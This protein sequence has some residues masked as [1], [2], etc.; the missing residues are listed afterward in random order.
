MTPTS[1]RNRVVHDD[2]PR[3]SRFVIAVALLASMAACSL[4]TDLGGLS[5][6]D[7]RD[8]GM[9]TSDGPEQDAAAAVDGANGSPT[10]GGDA[11]R[12]SDAMT[13]DA[14]ATSRYASAVIADA[15]TS[16]YRFGELA[17]PT[18]HDEMHLHDAVYRGAVTFGAAGALAGDPNASIR[19][20]G[21]QMAAVDFG[22]SFDCAGG[23]AFSIELWVDDHVIDSEYRRVFWTFGTDGG[24]WGFDIEQM[25]GLGVTFNGS[26]SSSVFVS[27]FPLAR[28]V[29]LAV[30]Y[31]TATLR[32]YLDGTLAGTGGSVNLPASSARLYLGMTDQG[33]NLFNGRIDELAFYDH[34]LTDAQIATHL[35]A[36]R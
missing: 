29:H 31:D 3:R 36:A 23:A 33:Y 4:V 11:A 16:F 18:A 5:S 26:A 27:S 35:A 13:A 19:L 2:M 30:T 14:L 32:V 28:F 22:Q 21:D 12:P 1:A 15:P 17:G 6:D 25:Y 34:A 9:T 8:G 24:G 7:G 20:P 10:D